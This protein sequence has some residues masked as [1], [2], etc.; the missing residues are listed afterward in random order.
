MLKTL[1]QGEVTLSYQ[2]LG[3]GFPVMLVHGFPEDGGVFQRLG[4]YLQK[5]F[6]VLIPD[7]PGSGGST[8]PATPLTMEIMAGY[9]EEIIRAEQI[10]SSIM[11]GHSMGGYVTIAYAQ[12]YPGKLK[13]FGFFH[14][15][16]LADTEEKKMLRQKSVEWMNRHGGEPFVRQMIPGLFGK[17][18][19]EEHPKEV[20]LL[21]SKSAKMKTTSLVAYYQAMM[22]R[23]DRT[24][25]LKETQVPVLFL[26]GTA[27]EILPLN[28][29]LAQ[30]ALPSVSALHLLEQV[31]HMGMLESEES[32]I[33]VWNFIQ[34][35]LC[36]IEKRIT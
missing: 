9:L 1:Q 22:G 11:I 19:R 13:G 25:L 34:F 6:R 15:S 5:D 20:D 7:L 17:K 23:P 3:K 30:A 27:D 36:R 16:G 26:L 18:F 32:N 28:Q 14:S 2:D 12:K 35:C 29:G 4:S 21:I 31:G 33:F 24:H 10:S 8:L